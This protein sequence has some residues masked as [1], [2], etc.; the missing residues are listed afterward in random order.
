MH[1]KYLHVYHVQVWTWLISV[2]TLTETTSW[3][4]FGRSWSWSLLR[5]VVLRPTWRSLMLNVYTY[6]WTSFHWW[7]VMSHGGTFLPSHTGCEG[8]ENKFSSF[9]GLL[10]YTV[11]G[12]KWTNSI[13]GITSSNIG[14]FS[15]FF[16]CRNLL[17]IC[18]KIGIKFPI[19]PQT[20]RYTTLWKTDVRKLVTQRDATHHFVA[21][22]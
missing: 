5:A 9:Y 8:L 16:Q 13:L 3:L 7:V 15:K 20:C 21:Q 18:N 2:C 4:G 22:N 6:K 17:E 19:T 12:K 11:S 10:L 1:V 14:R